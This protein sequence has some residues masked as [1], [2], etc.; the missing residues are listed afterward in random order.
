MKVLKFGG[1]SVGSTDSIKQVGN[2][3]K[4]YQDSKVRVI[5]VVSAQNGIT[6]LLQDIGSWAVEGDVDQINQGIVTIQDRHFQT[7]KEL[8]PIKDQEQ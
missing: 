7:V 3:L 5:V 8:L 4:Q 6:N 1:T 2:I